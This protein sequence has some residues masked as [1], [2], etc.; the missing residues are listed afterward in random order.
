MEIKKRYAC[1]IIS[2][3]NNFSDQIHFDW[4]I[5]RGDDPRD[6]EKMG[7]EIERMDSD[8]QRIRD[9]IEEL[10]RNRLTTVPLK[11]LKTHKM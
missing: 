2:L 6:I 10:D 11:S 1:N 7:R 5:A 4:A 3:S 8:L 9:D